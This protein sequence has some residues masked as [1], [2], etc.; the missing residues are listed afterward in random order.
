MANRL[1]VVWIELLKN[2]DHRFGLAQRLVEDSG[3]SADDRRVE[4]GRGLVQ[5]RRKRPLRMQ[6]S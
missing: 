4:C 5:L 3:T 2:V 6:V 1:A